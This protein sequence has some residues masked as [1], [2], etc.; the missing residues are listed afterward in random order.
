ME[1]FMC[2]AQEPR[3]LFRSHRPRLLQVKISPAEPRPKDV[4]PRFS[5]LRLATPFQGS[6]GVTNYP[7]YVTANRCDR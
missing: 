7:A 4:G 1:Y 5:A 3:P 6:F 2:N